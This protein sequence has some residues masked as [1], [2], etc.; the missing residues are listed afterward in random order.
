MV[1]I[2]KKLILGPQNPLLD[3][4]SGQLIGL[5]NANDS[6]LPEDKVKTDE[7][8]AGD[9]I[10]SG[11]QGAAI[12]AKIEEKKIKQ[13][14]PNKAPLVATSNDGLGNKID[15][16]PVNQEEDFETQDI[17]IDEELNLIGK[18][19]EELADEYGLLRQNLED[20]QKEDKKKTGGV[21]NILTALGQGRGG[22]DLTPLLELNLAQSYLTLETS[23]LQQEGQRQ[24]V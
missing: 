4:D 1:D 10:R 3:Q 22:L 21:A 6:G 8:K 20:W 16:N 5:I 23:V 14:L 24:T 13:E 19:D 7:Q 18:S 11:T 15:M 12:Q 2:A 17:A 9:I